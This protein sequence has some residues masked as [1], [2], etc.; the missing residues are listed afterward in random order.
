[1]LVIEPHPFYG[2]GME[3]VALRLSKELQ[4]RGHEIFLVYETDGTMLPAY[5]AIVSKK[6][7]MQLPGFPMRRPFTI[8]A[9]VWRLIKLIK[10]HRI[11]RIFSSHLGFIRVCAVIR[12]LTGTPAFFHLGLP[13]SAMPFSVS[14]AL[15]WMGGGISPAPHTLATWTEKSWPDETL[16]QVRNWVDGEEFQ[17]AP[18]KI[19]LR[20]GLAMSP[21]AFVIGFVGRI[22]REKGVEVLVDAFNLVVR[23]WPE[24]RLLMGGT[25]DQDY[26][27]ELMKRC[28]APEKFRVLP[29]TSRPQEVYGAIDVICV[30]SIW[31]EPYPLVLLEAMA[32]GLAITISDVGVLPDIL[33]E[34]AAEWVCAAGDVEDLAQ[35]LEKLANDPVQTRRQGVKMRERALQVYGPKDPV[36]QYEA[37]MLG[38]AVHEDQSVGE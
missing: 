25:F 7:R 35:K 11:D 26:I 21:D 12:I 33:G 16:W 2:G 32:S 20:A 19:E 14:F 18:N 36:T 15:R 13:G 5:D 27:D 29:R 30:P 37:I 38:T 34:E 22:V 3:A 1:V 4:R 31:E 9:L 8:L 17:P 6:F 24:C 10:V 23:K 28:D